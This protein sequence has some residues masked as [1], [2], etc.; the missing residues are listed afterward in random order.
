MSFELKTIKVELKNY[1][2]VVYLNRPKLNAMNMQ[3]FKDLLSCFTRLKEDSSVR[4]ILLVSAFKHFTAGLDLKEA[5]SFPGT[6]DLDPARA[7]FQFMTD[8]GLMQDSITA[9]EACKKPVIV[10]VNGLCIGGGIDLI[11]ACDIRLC[12]AD[13]KFTVKEVD[14][15]LAADLGTLQ[16][17]P[18]VIND[19]CFTGRFFDAKEALN[20]GLVSRIY[21]DP[22]QLFEEGFK[23]AVEI[24]DKPP[25]ATKSIKEVLLYSRDHSVDDGLKYVSVWNSVML[26]SPDTIT[27][28]TAALSKSKGTYSKL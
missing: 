18:K 3:F 17:L 24:G 1:V 2:A 20:F 12:S 13:A 9:I 7:A 10:G 21:E 14:V 25:I 26:N 28:A 23:L 8:L 15:G 4:S 11:T 19:I 22:K 27:A 16:R 6:T 5:V